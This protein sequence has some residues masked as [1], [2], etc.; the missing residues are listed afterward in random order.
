MVTLPSR[1]FTE[2]KCQNKKLKSNLKSRLKLKMPRKL[3]LK[4]WPSRLWEVPGAPDWQNTLSLSPQSSLTCT[5][6]HHRHFHCEKN[7]KNVEMFFWHETSVKNEN[8]RQ[9]RWVELLI[10]IL[11]TRWWTSS[12]NNTRHAAYYAVHNQEYN[13]VWLTSFSFKHHVACKQEARSGCT[14]RTC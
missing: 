7:A 14:K 8:S 2:D 6:F 9:M 3:I 1:Q 12:G 13:F 10:F 11:A 5:F 4:M